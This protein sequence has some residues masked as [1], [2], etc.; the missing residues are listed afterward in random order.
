MGQGKTPFFSSF[1]WAY[2]LL[3][4]PNVSPTIEEAERAKEME[5]KKQKEVEATK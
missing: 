5:N 2:K 4:L 3:L 1:D